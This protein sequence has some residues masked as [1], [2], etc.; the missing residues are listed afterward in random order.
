MKE[1]HGI[2]KNGRFELSL[3]QLQQRQSYLK[4]LTD[5]TRVIETLRKE[6]KSKSW[7]QV[8][9]HF[10]FALMRIVEEMESRGWDSSIIYNLPKST[11][12]P[13]SKDMLHLFFY[14]MFPIYNDAGERITMSHNDWTSKNSCELFDNVRNFAASQWSI[15]IP[16]PD[17][18]WK[19]KGAN[20][21]QE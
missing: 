18:N 10:G 3:T 11:G 13:V 6:G 14:V 4:N 2:I 8:K 21:C 5:D 9:T 15:Y 7:E 12:V 16:E 17:K 19:D 20:Q 1:F